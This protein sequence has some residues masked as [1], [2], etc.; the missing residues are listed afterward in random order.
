MDELIKTLEALEE[1]ESD[2]DRLLTVY[3]WTVNNNCKGF[4][5]GLYYGRVQRIVKDHIFAQA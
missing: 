1:W 2:H 4:H 5:D 3:N